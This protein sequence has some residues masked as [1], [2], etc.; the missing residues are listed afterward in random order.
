MGCL[1][2]AAARTLKLGR[3][4]NIGVLFADQTAVGLTL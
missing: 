1:P 2:N 4:H 3:S